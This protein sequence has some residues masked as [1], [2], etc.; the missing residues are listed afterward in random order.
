LLEAGKGGPNVGVVGVSRK[1]ILECA[2]CRI[3]TARRVLGHGVH[4]RETCVFG[5]EHS[6]TLELTECLTSSTQAHQ[7]KAESMVEHAVSRG[8]L[9]SL[10]HHTFTIGVAPDNAKQISEIHIGGNEG[11]LQTD[12]RFELVFGPRDVPAIAIE[13]PQVQPE[14]LVTRCG[15][16]DVPDVRSILERAGPRRLIA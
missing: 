11:G 1:G 6:G 4:V 8:D 14:Y 3:Y 10:P 16:G 12:C 15:I 7:S 2:D 9:E 13:G 5:L